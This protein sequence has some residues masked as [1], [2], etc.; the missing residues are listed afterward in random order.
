M[1]YIDDAR[2]TERHQT[3]ATGSQEKN[4]LRAK[5]FLNKEDISSDT[6]TS[7]IL[8]PSSGKSMCSTLSPL[9]PL[10]LHQ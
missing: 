3:E 10:L 8:C 7:P 6:Q 9:S 1:K 2:C 5:D 4:E